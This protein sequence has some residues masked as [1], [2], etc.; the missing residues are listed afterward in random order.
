MSLIIEQMDVETTFLKVDASSELYVHQPKGYK[1]GT[2]R[3]CELTK[4]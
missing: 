3:V 2:N 1:E 4:A